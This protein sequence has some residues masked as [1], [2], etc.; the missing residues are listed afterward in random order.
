M[1]KN[2]MIFCIPIAVSPATVYYLVQN[3][4]EN[5]VEEYSTYQNYLANKQEK[6]VEK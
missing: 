1:I 3:L 2:Q 6:P 4:I 5:G